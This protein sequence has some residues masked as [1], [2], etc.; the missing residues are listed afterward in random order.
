M[1]G[2]SGE[3]LSG[4]VATTEFVEERKEREWWFE[5]GVGRRQLSLIY[6]EQLQRAVGRAVSFIGHEISLVWTTA[7]G[8]RSKSQPQLGIPLVLP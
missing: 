5:N 6:L 2:H 7:K 1:P 8:V 3:Q 4:Q